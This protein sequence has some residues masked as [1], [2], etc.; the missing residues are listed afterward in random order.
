M[1]LSRL[2]CAALLA[3]CPATSLLADGAADNQI[4]NVR[5]LPPPG[6]R[7]TDGKIKMNT[8]YPGYTIRFTTD[9]SEPGPQSR[10]YT[11]PFTHT[12]VQ[13]KAA[14]FDERGRMGFVTSWKPA[15]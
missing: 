15:E 1:I 9:G 6:V 11:G 10:R 3:L 14:C 2:I 5:R 4:E 12:G 7:L 8:A 13:I